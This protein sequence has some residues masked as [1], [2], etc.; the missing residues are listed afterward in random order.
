[1]IKCVAQ[2]NLNGV[3]KA[4]NHFLGVMCVLGVLGVLGAREGCVFVCMCVR[5]LALCGWGLYFGARMYV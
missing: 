5:A 2:Q 1:M 4:E 3:A